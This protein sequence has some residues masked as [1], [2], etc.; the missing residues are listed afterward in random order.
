MYPIMSPS[1]LDVHIEV[2]NGDKN[3]KSERKTA[4]NLGIEVR[5]TYEKVC[6]SSKIISM[7]RK[8]TPTEI[9]ETYPDAY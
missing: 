3:F 9:R 5:H 2:T 1:V 7:L 8:P 4:A 6:S